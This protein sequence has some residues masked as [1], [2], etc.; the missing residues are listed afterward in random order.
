MVY[1]LL[2]VKKTSLLKVI[3]NISES[4][5][6]HNTIITTGTFDGVH[7][8]HRQIFRHMRELSEKSGQ[9]TVVVTFHPHPRIVLKKEPEKLHLVSTIDEKISLINQTGIDFLVVLEFDMELAAL[10]PEEF[11]CKILIRK[12][13]AKT[14]FVG[15]D[16][17]FGKNQSGNKN[18]LKEVSCKHKLE[19][20]EVSAL[21]RQGQTVSSSLIRQQLEKGMV[22]AAA[23]NLGYNYRISGKVVK[24]NM[25]GRK[26]GFPTANI[27]LQD[28][29]KLMPGRGVYAVRVFAENQWHKGML[30][31]GKRPT[32]N[33]SKATVE[34]H[35]FDYNANLYDEIITIEFIR[36]IREEKKFPNLDELG[37]Q[38]HKDR[39]YAL[40]VLS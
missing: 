22:E 3:R 7:E 26:I 9:P 16:H 28:K 12:L 34:V 36:F 30:N 13:G 2:H 40:Q 33:T 10:S 31:I 29:L 17:Q 19:V 5:P 11:I 8:G 18:T 37:S 39:K 21:S 4:E 27:E 25:L 1:V 6:L 20:K 32:L 15:Y 23:K 24:G 38:L 14:V 35:L